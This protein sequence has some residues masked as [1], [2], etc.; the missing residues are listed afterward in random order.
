MNR[1]KKI[2]AF[3]LTFCTITAVFA[4][5][6]KK[7]NTVTDITLTTI[8]SSTD[9]GTEKESKT[10]VTLNIVTKTDADAANT[11]SSSVKKTD[12]KEQTVKT[13]QPTTVKRNISNDKVEEKAVGISLLSKSDPVK[14]GNHATIIIQGTPGKTYSIEFYESLTKIANYSGL[15]EVK[16]D[17]NGFASWSFKIQNTCDL[18]TRKIIIKENNSDNYLQTSITIK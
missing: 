5:C 9:D 15:T 8:E 11:N 1:F 13:T 18:G 7:D 4:S 12:L 2:S 16:A 14:T 10:S 17:E 3:I 6:G